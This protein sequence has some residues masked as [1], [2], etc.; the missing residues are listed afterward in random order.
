MAHAMKRGA[1]MLGILLAL[2]SAI[3]VVQASLAEASTG[4]HVAF[5]RTSS[6]LCS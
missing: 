5:R 6:P 2:L 3:Q 1:V 4:T